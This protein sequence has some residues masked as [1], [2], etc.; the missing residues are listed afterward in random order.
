MRNEEFTLVI[1]E[2]QYYFKL[3]EN[4]RSKDD[5]L[6]YIERERL[7]KHDKSIRQNERESLKYAE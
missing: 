7:I 6:R 1:S 3:K 2:E 5:W 4:I